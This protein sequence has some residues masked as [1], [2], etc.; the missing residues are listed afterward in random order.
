MDACWFFAN[1]KEKMSKSLGNFF[2]IRD[3]LQE[4]TPEVVTLFFIVQSLSQSIGL[5]RMTLLTSK[6]ITGTLLYR[7]ATFTSKL[8]PIRKITAYET[9]FI[10][11]MDDDFNPY[12][13]RS[14]IY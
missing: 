14:Q 4:H 3:L 12:L 13:S 5:F 8:K 10:E 6:P 11:A 1:R 2:T 7:I 9:K